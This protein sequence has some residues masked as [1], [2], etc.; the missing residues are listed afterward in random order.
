MLHFRGQKARALRSLTLGAGASAP[1]PGAALFRNGKDVG[2]VTSSA[3]GLA[4]EPPAVL[5][6]VLREGYEPGTELRVGSTDGPLGRVESPPSL[7][8]PG[9]QR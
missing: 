6:I 5:A 3:A 2:R 1:A 8:P 7:T 9:A 4:G